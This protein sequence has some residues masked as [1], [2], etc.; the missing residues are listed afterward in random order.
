MAK[1]NPLLDKQRELAKKMEWR[2]PGKHPLGID[3][4]RIR[5]GSWKGWTDTFTVLKRGEF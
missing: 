2:P 5:P 3:R 4:S 1:K